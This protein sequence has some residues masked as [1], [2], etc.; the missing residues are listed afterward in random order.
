MENGT[1]RDSLC[2]EVTNIA[3]P[4]RDDVMVSVRITKIQT[5]FLEHGLRDVWSLYLQTHFPTELN[6]LKGEPSEHY[7][8]LQLFFLFLYLVKNSQ[9]FTFI[10]FSIFSDITSEM[11]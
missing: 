7:S 9:F 5:Y 2:E 1:S 10:F 6:E 8:S 4:S 3:L 11:H